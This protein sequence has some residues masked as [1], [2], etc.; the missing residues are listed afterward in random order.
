MAVGSIIDDDTSAVLLMRANSPRLNDTAMRNATTRPSNCRT[1]AD[2][3]TWRAI[4]AFSAAIAILIMGARNGPASAQ[5]PVTGEVQQAPARVPVFSLPNGDVVTTTI[6]SP[7]TATAAAAGPVPFTGNFT[8]S[9]FDPV[10]PGS[11][12]FVGTALSGSARSMVNC[13]VNDFASPIFTGQCAP[14]NVTGASPAA[15]ASAQMQ[16]DD[17]VDTRE[18]EAGRGIEP[19]AVNHLFDPEH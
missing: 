6:T 10:A 15:V 13:T 17:S 1:A 18:A 11:A 2:V 12:T 14:F 8:L 16:S 4:S 7:T 9:K 19:E 3:M 5:M